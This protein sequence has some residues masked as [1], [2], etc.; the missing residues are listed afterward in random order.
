MIRVRGLSWVATAVREPRAMRGCCGR[1][2]NRGGFWIRRSMGIQFRY[3]VVTPGFHIIRIPKAAGT[4]IRALLEHASSDEGRGDDA[5]DGAIVNPGIVE[6]QLGITVVDRVYGSR[7]ERR[8]QLWRLFYA[9]ARLRRL[10]LCPPWGLPKLGL[11]CPGFRRSFAGL[12]LGPIFGGVTFQ[13]SRSDSS[14]SDH[15]FGVS[16]D[17]EAKSSHFMKVGFRPFAGG[18]C[19][20]SLFLGILTVSAHSQDDAATARERAQ[21]YFEEDNA[22]KAVATLVA[23]AR[24]NPGDR[25]TGALI[26]SGLRDHVW[27]IPQI[28]PIKHQASVNALV[29]NHDSSLFASGSA[30]GELFLS[31]TQPLEAAE[32]DSHRVALPQPSGI[33]GLAFSRN[34]KRLAVATK[35]DG[36]RVID[37]AEKKV[38]FIAPKPTGE[39]VVFSAAREAD[40][41]GIGTN[42]GAIQAV[43]FSAGKVILDTSPKAGEVLAISVSK[44]GGKL[45]AG[46]GDRVA[47]VWNLATGQLIGKGVPHDAALRAVDFSHNER[48]VMSAGEAGVIRLSDP[49]A[50][51]LAMPA[52]QCPALVKTASVSPDG[53][54]IAA[55]LDDGSVQFWDAFTSEKRQCAMSEDGQFQGFIWA[56][57]ALRGATY[58]AT[59]NAITWTLRDG[60]RRGE[61]MPQGA[62]IVSAAI[63]PDSVYLATGSSDGV[64][65]LWRTDGGMPMATVRSH[66]ARARSAFYSLDGKRLVTTSDDHTA[67]H[68]ISGQVAPAGPALKH[69]GKVTCAAITADGAKILTCDDT[70]IAQFWLTSTSQVDRPAYVHDKPVNW[71]DI[72]PDGKRCL[73]AAGDTVRIWSVSEIGAPVATIRHPSENSEIKCV[74]FSPDGKWIV[75]AS[76]DGFARVWDGTTYREAGEAI[77]RDFPILCVRFSPDGSRLVVAGEDGQAVVFESGTWRPV[78]VPIQAPG[79]VFSAA[80]T[81]DNRFVVISSLLLNAVQFFEIASGRALGAGVP[82][83]AQATCVDYHIKDKVVIVACDDGCVRAVDSPFVSQ[84]VPGW[85][86]EFAERIIGLKK[87]G[88][89]SYERVEGHIGQLR[90]L[91]TNEAKAPDEDFARLAR[92]KLTIGPERNGM[93]RFKSTIAANIE[94]RVEER[95]VDAL[96]ECL[97][98]VSNEPQIL[99][100]LSL[101]LPNARH[102]E[103]LADLVLSMEQAD[104]L[105]RCY[106]A[107]TLI[108]SGRSQE[109][110]ALIV[111]AVQDAPEDSKVLRRAAKLRARLLQKEEAIELFE[112]AIRFDPLSAETARAYGW[113]LYHFQQPKDAAAEFQRAQALAGDMVDDL[114][115][116]LCLCAAAQNDLESARAL[117]RRLVIIDPLWKEASFLQTL[118]GW[119]QR[120]LTELENVRRGL[121]AGR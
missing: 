61:T 41:I 86:A 80:I 104:S 111:K 32:A 40:V 29:L 11:G 62:P 94:K 1:M 108:R 118:P 66:A 98:S 6:H 26:Y 57:S 68:W 117:Y 14:S 95:S 20:V 72:A 30:T 2:V 119:S 114:V 105:S 59:G 79:P 49:E 85:M 89:D 7:M 69:R 54:T 90:S 58:S 51:V 55:V 81:S 77:K 65:R 45:A 12:D 121:F 43:D 73:T 42:Q 64:A 27:H 103:Y 23:S 112:K 52:I 67:L 78:G 25:I 34:G 91:M 56:R 31:T 106:A 28:L 21:S 70:G 101:F 92:W 8:K 17:V 22:R 87:T 36:V 53:S 13:D 113:A 60:T 75:T 71:V 88:P 82:I 38:V 24:K 35:S 97:E 39:A 33:V 109:A 5:Q 83:P 107:G 50:G 102:G 110:E 120:E 47:R 37:L 19:R 44:S 18:L 16:A 48:Y 74:R 10:S 84:D 15:W 76:T 4:F 63:S 100:A 9:Q 115:A 46:C 93:P 99:S 96:F 116:G 3:R